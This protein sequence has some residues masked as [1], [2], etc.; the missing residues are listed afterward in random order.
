MDRSEYLYKNGRVAFDGRGWIG[1]DSIAQRF[2]VTT[3]N[4]YRQDFPFLAQIS[5]TEVKETASSNPL[6]TTA[7]SLVNQVTDSVHRVTIPV[8]RQTSYEAGRTAH[9]VEVAHDYDNFS[10]IVK[11]MI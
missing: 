3:M 11:T 8:I 2:E 10:N 7:Y 5:K 4:I 6:K 1:F 9:L